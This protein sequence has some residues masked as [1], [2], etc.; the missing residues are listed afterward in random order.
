MRALPQSELDEINSI[1]NRFSPDDPNTQ[2]RFLFDSPL[3]D[4]GTQRSDFAA[5]DAE[6]RD[7]RINGI[8]RVVEA[9]GFEGVQRLA[10]TVKEVFS[11]GWTLADA[12][13]YDDEDSVLQ[14]LDSDDQCHVAFARGYARNARTM[15][16]EFEWMSSVFFGLKGAQPLQARVLGSSTDL[17]AIWPR[18]REL[19]TPIKDVYWEK[20]HACWTG[21]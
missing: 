15:E 7:A 4:L 13:L 8:R 17:Q 18:A 12:G 6:L 11:L 19:G 5:Y 14:Y 10:D 21:H 9:E 3:P 1:A 16:K 2:I 20:I